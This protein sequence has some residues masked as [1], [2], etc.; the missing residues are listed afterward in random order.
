MKN[1]ASKAKKISK[2]RSVKTLQNTLKKKEKSFEGESKL[3]SNKVNEVAELDESLRS[4][5]PEEEILQ[6]N[7]ILFINSLET[8]L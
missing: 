1:V 2:T 6:S 8:H 5:I 3:S 4:K 7:S